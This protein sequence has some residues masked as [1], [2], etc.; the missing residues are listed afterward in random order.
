M[1][2]ADYLII[3]VLAFS[4]LLGLF[5][6]FLREAI[7]VIAW[8]GGLWLAWRYA[9]LVE[10]LLGG[11]LDNPPV[12]TWAARAIIVVA[13]L[14][15][16]WLVASVLGYLLRHSSLSIMVDRFLGLIFGFIRGAVVIAAVVMLAQF[17][18]LDNMPWWKKSKLL[19]FTTEYAGWIQSFAETG[20]RLLNEQTRSSHL[21]SLSLPT[22]RI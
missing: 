12:S 5:R 15:I 4:S 19:P 10:P 7:G 17:V 16:G 1:N 21:S 14:I 22:Q 8:L 9:P 18:Q 11:A 6:G 2:G 3:G 20:M 13:V